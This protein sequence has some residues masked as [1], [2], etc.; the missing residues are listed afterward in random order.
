MGMILICHCD[1]SV[2]GYRKQSPKQSEDCQHSLVIIEQSAL[3]LQGLDSQWHN[4]YH[5]NDTTF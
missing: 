4:P 2:G 3:A 1:G 5:A